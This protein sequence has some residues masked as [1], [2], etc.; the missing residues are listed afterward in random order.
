MKPASIRII[1]I[2]NQL[3]KYTSERILEVY[4]LLDELVKLRKV[5]RNNYSWR[6]L[7]NERGLG[8]TGSQIRY[9]QSYSFI[10]P[11]T[12]KLIKQGKVTESQVCHLIHRFRFLRE[13]QWQ[14]KLMKA[15]FAGKIKMSFASELSE[16]LIKAILLGKKLITVKDQRLISFTKTIRSFSS[17]LNNMKIKKNEQTKHLVNVLKDLIKKLD[18]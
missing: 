2:K 1:E 8:L 6:S 14:S 17:V 5:Q 9:V 15:F 4:N 12:L 10:V 7:E 16:S 11:S 18:K 13:E 3:R